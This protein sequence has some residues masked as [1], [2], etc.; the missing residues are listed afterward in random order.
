MSKAAAAN[1]HVVRARL[2]LHGGNEFAAYQGDVKSEPM[3]VEL[4]ARLLAAVQQGHEAHGFTMDRLFLATPILLTGEQL[5][6]VYIES[7]LNELWDG[8]GRYLRVN[9]IVLLAPLLLAVGIGGRAQRVIS[10]PI[11]KLADITKAVTNERRYDLRAE[12]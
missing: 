7:D 10:Q 4:G 5:G 9:A 2:V 1:P 12:S 6:A 11:V 3:P 8:A